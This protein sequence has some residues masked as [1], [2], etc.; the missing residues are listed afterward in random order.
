IGRATRFASF[1]LGC[2]PALQ[3]GQC[4]SGYSCAYSS[5]ISWR[6]PHTPVAKEINPRL[7]FERLFMIGSFAES[8]AERMQRLK[9]Q[10]SILD[11]VQADAHRLRGK[12]GR[13][14]RQ[15]MDEYFEAVRE[16]ERRIEGIEKLGRQEKKIQ[17]D[18]KIPPGI[19]RDYREH[20]R[21]MYDLMVLAFRLDLT[22]VSS[23]M[24]SNE[25]SNRNYGFIGAPGGHHSLSHHGGDRGKINRIRAINRF[26][27]E[28]FARFLK[29]LKAVREGGETLLDN[30]MCVYGSALSDG[31]RH[32]HDHLPVLL[33]GNG[34]G[35]IKTGRH[36][37]YARETPLCNLYLTMLRELG[38]EAKT[39]G[40]STGF[41]PGLT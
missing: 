8:A 27:A 12:L 38:V 41:L 19:P 28:E 25:A 33:A 11:M 24:V 13:T 29:T 6:T 18:L 31:N 4:D 5:N 23:F 15:K 37:R 32:N 35:R 36:I 20:V 1:E 26:H 3:S 17:N 40:D 34:G 16:I 7:A 30:T 21:L 39:F 9:E 10:K 22:R 2:E 14:D